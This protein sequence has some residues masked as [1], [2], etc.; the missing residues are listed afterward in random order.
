MPSLT[1]VQLSCKSYLD[2]E[3][4]ENNVIYCHPPYA[5]T[6]KYRDGLEHEQFWEWCRK[7]SQA[8]HQVFISE[9]SAPEDLKCIWEKGAKTTFSWHAKNLYTKESVERLFVFIA[10]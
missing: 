4:P 10:I 1:G 3:I 7:Q 6:T 8:G 5:F 9:Y 2:L